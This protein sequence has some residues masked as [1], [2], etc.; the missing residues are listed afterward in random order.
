[1]FD[2]NLPSEEMF[3]ETVKRYTGIFID[4]FNP[5]ICRRLKDRVELHYWYKHL[6]SGLKKP[7]EE[8]G[9]HFIGRELNFTSRSVMNIDFIKEAVEVLQMD[10]EDFESHRYLQFV[11]EEEY[12][13]GVFLA[14]PLFY[15]IQ[16]ESKQIALPVWLH[17]FHPAHGCCEKIKK[18]RLDLARKIECVLGAM[19]SIEPLQ[20]DYDDPTNY[21]QL[22]FTKSRARNTRTHKRDG[23]EFTGF[24]KHN[25][26]EK[27]IVE[28]EKI[29]EKEVEKIVKVYITPDGNAF[30]E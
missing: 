19:N 21:L 29:V 20:Y 4:S 25:H 24:F 18:Y 27:E 12:S 5:I 26:G 7:F 13:A 17:D 3:V 22:K 6:P 8:N 14:G 16:N 11:T 2:E 10:I 23:A 30:R 1:M 9:V 28:V 15:E